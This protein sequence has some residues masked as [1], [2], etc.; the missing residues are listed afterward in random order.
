MK[1]TLLALALALVAST[2]SIA[3]ITANATQANGI[4]YTYVQLDYAYVGSHY[5]ENQQDGGILSGSWQFADKFHVFG[6]YSDFSAQH[7]S[8]SSKPWTLGFGFA[9]AIGSKV[10]WV[11]RV[12]F[13]HDGVHANVCSDFDCTTTYRA[14]ANSNTYFAIAGV[15]G[16][17]TD[18]LTLN[19]YLGY[20]DGDHN[21]QAF[22]A[23]FGAVYSFS[24]SGQRTVLTVNNDNSQTYSVGVRASF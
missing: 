1:K 17:V 21:A 2:A 6:S 23:D 8:L 13:S 19:A 12:A 9:N 15:M 7:Y 22:Y 16:R 18:N 10:D 5:R 20:H 4:G 11:S 3:P 14:H 24:R